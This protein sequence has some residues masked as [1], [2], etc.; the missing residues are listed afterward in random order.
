M[1]VPA[2]PFPSFFAQVPMIILALFKFKD[3]PQFPFEVFGTACLVILMVIKILDEY[4]FT[5]LDRLGIF[6][7]EMNGGRDY[8][9]ELIQS[10][11]KF[12]YLTG[13]TIETFDDIVR[14][15]RLPILNFQR[16]NSRHTATNNKKP[17]TSN[18]DMA[19]TI[20]TPTNTCSYVQDR[21]NIY[22]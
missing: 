8:Y 2:V 3:Y 6:G 7:P 1:D 14:R 9:A 12:W 22:K 11:I 18:F 15:M 10:P 13:E 21:C 5:V 4:P 16:R 19:E 20:S 17:A